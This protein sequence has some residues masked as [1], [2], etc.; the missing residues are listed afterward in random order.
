MEYYAHSSPGKERSQWHLLSDHLHC[1][2]RTAAEFARAFG[3]ER[4][5]FASGL[6][7]DIGKYSD[8]FQR[9]LQGDPTRV[10]H[11]TV[12]AVEATKRYGR[13]IGLILA[14]AIAGHHAG[15]PDYGS[16]ADGDSLSRRLQARD[17]PDY[18]A[19][20]AEVSG[21]L[22]DISELAVPIKPSYGNPGFSFQFLIRFLFSCLIDADFLDTEAY[23]DPQRASARGRYPSLTELWDKLDRYLRHLSKQAED[24]QVNRSRAETLESCLNKAELPPGMFTLT[25]PT[26][27]GK[28]LSS[29]AFAMKHAL[30]H[31]M[32]R[33]IYVIPF[34]SII[35]QNAG[36]FRE[37][38]GDDVVLEHHSNFSFPDEDE[39]SLTPVQY[40]LRLSAENW[41]APL[42]VTTN[43]QFYESLFSAKGSRCRKLHNIARSVVIL[44]EAQTLPIQFLRPCLQSL[45]ELV[46]NYGA[47][48]V[49][50]TATQPSIRSF[51]PSNLQVVELA[52]NPRL[53]Y[54]TLKR[55]SVEDL[56]DIDD[57]SL[58]ERLSQHEQVLCIVNTRKHALK[59]AGLM[60]GEEL[61]HLS[62][63]MCP[64][65]R[66][67]KLAEILRVLHERL[68]CR[69]VST[70]L[71][72]AGVDIDFP[73]VY[74]ALAG[75][76]SVAQAAG[77]C[78]REGKRPIGHVYLFRPEAHGLP[79]GW[80]SRTASVSS[81]VLRH[82]SD[83]LSLEAVDLYFEQLYDVER[84]KLDKEG[85]LEGI[86][87]RA[88]KLAFEFR[89]MAG[90]VKLIDDVTD[91][92]VIPFDDK[93]CSLLDQARYQ[94][95]S[96]NLSRQLQPY[97]VQVYSNELRRLLEMNAVEVV[98][99]QYTVLCDMA[100]YSDDVGLSY[101]DDRVF[102]DTLM[103]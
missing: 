71:I 72:E 65:H 51:L 103:V 22:P 99:G 9:R 50:C 84:E 86:D 15:L 63:R 58:V 57:A 93:C 25:V 37:V 32:N 83:P 67:R 95:P 92:I 91:P 1:T 97:T 59:L 19:F 55:V 18:S 78:N 77:R 3:A 8:A 88:N 53:L 66:S 33:I 11:S 54:Q 4:L 2:A 61:Y 89:E 85:I 82:H 74:R 79:I 38:L 87:E 48:V 90:K 94:G 41:D 64:A 70:Q 31:D 68:R 10:D 45:V 52:P 60:S 27:G 49:L 7:H 75:I 23:M 5:G 21:V 56:G 101:P 30:T 44:D 26:G 6:L 20:R 100:L 46:T 76:D 62:G 47:S 81:A 96:V 36:R 13:A 34:T 42:I 69:V 12:G 17:L 14:Y 43:V 80:F 16:V 40:R 73:V 98:A 102:T 39:E 28:T 24:T 35:E 29:L